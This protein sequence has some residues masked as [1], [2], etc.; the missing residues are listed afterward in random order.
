MDPSKPQDE[1][2]YKISSQDGEKCGIFQQKEIT[3]VKLGQ[4]R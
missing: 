2:I 3:H 1:F 4:T